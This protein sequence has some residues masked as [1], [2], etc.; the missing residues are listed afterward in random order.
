M[1]RSPRPREGL[2]ATAAWA[3]MLAGRAASVEASPDVARSTGGRERLTKAVAGGRVSLS[4]EDA[5]WCSGIPPAAAKGWVDQLQ[6][7]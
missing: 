2:S 5:R 7:L 3:K 6:Q 1:E 4:T